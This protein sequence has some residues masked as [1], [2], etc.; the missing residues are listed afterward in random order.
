[1]QKPTITGNS[2]AIPSSQDYLADV[3]NFIEGRLLEFGLEKSVI[4]DIAISVTEMV[5]NGIIHGNKSIPNKAVT[6]ALEK[7]DDAVEI[8]I[9]DQGAGFDPETIDN[10]IDEKNLLKEVG[11]GIFIVKSLMDR[12]DIRPTPEGTEVT[13]VKNI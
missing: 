8:T 13:L 6:I 3:D 4:A 9:T 11:R 2:I 12:V 1:M 7:K 10:P 5:I